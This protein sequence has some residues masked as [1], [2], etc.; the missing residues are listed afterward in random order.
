[1]KEKDYL[2]F[3]LFYKEVLYYIQFEARIKHYT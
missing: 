2:G 1:M 3:I